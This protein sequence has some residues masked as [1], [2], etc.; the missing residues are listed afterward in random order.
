M[1]CGLLGFCIALH[2]SWLAAAGFFVYIIVFRLCLFLVVLFVA[3]GCKLGWIHLY[4]Y[5][6]C[7]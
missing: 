2:Y 3:G 7:C 6:Y 4:M 5:Y 1:V